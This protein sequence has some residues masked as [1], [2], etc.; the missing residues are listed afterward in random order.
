MNELSR[1]PGWG[2]VGRFFLNAE[3][4]ELPNGEKTLRATTPLEDLPA[5][6][7]VCGE[8]GSTFDLAWELVK[9]DRL[10]CWG[11]VLAAS[12]LAGR[13]QLRRHWVS[14]AGNLYVT[15]RLPDDLNT[16]AGSLLTGYLLLQ[17]L[18]TL[19]AKVKIKWPNDLIQNGRKVGGI[20]LEERGGVLLAGVGLNLRQAPDTAKLQ[21]ESERA[22]AFP[23]GVLYSENAPVSCLEGDILHIWLKL[24]KQVT[25]SYE[26]DL[27]PL[28]PELRA[29]VLEEHLAFK[30]SKVLVQEPGFYAAEPGQATKDAS[31]VITGLGP[32]GE[33]RLLLTS[34]QELLLHSGTLIL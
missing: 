10:P 19:G 2:G 16:E 7:F 9:Q 14:D 23:A 25:L 26:K 32:K 28:T 22:Q 17:A 18:H 15:F 6:G 3:A 29:T 1:L 13:G 27:V 11:F 12:Q 24:V 4:F 31:G 8:V 20:L 30:G 34:G 5:P 33:L 21:L